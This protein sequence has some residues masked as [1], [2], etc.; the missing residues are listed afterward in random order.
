MS[1]QPRAQE[2]A[3]QAFESLTDDDIDAYTN[4][5]LKHSA[6][7]YVEARKFARDIAGLVLHRLAKQLQGEN[8]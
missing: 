4:I 1:K 6:V 2:L 8:E 7:A 5:H 3:A